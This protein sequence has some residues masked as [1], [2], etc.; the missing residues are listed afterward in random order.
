MKKILTLSAMFVL[1][2]VATTS[3]RAQNRVVLP[4][5]LQPGANV[6]V[7]GSGYFWTD[8]VT[9]AMGFGYLG[10]DGLK[11]GSTNT[12]DP[13]TGA[14]TTTTYSARYPQSNSRYS[15]G[16]QGNWSP[17]TATRRTTW[18]IRTASR[19]IGLR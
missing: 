10:M 5:S 14:T 19:G 8:P 12:I 13:N 7:P 15:G 4:S 2:L 11:H 9:G 16:Q 3:A 1:T 6:M 17:V 18:C